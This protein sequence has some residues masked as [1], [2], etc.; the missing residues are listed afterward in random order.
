MCKKLRLKESKLVAKITV[1]DWMNKME[2]K[3]S[4]IFLLLVRD[5]YQVLSQCSVLMSK[6]KSK[7][8]C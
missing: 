3:M 5:Y 7:Q 4:H 2:Q 1:C 8:T 6:H